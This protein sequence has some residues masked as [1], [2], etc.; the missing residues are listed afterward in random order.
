V[1]AT[2]SSSDTAARRYFEAAEFLHLEAELLDDNRIAEWFALVD[3]DIDYR[4]PIRVTRERAAGAGFS[5]EGWHMYEDHGSLAA[6]VARL[7]TEYAWAEDPPSRTRRLVTNIRVEPDDGD[8]ELRVRSNLLIYRGRYDSPDFSLL[9]GER[10]DVLRRTAEGLRLLKRMVLLD[11]A[12]VATHN[13]A[14][15][16]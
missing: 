6:R 8:D 13:L 12:T 15:F 9:V 2:E 3:P 14:I 7:E 4:V 10:H 11:Q 16:L 5:T 1:A